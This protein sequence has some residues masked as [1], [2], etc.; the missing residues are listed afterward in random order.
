METFKLTF[1]HERCKEKPTT[2][3]L[4]RYADKRGNKRSHIQVIG[5]RIASGV[6]EVSQAQLEK[7]IQNGITWMG[8]VYSKCPQWGK[9]RRLENLWESMSAIVVDFDDNPDVDEIFATVRN[10]GMD[11][12]IFH[13]TFNWKQNHGKYRG[14][15][16]LDEPITDKQ[17]AYFTNYYFESLFRTEFDK[18]CKDLARLF[19]GGRRDCITY[20]SSFRA[21]YSGFS[22]YI[23]ESVK[24]KVL[25]D[26]FS[27]RTA[28]NY[29]FAGDVSNELSSVAD[30]ASFEGVVSQ[31]QEFA[32]LEA[33]ER[34][35]V[36][37]KVNHEIDMIKRFDGKYKNGGKQSRYLML[38]NTSRSLG[39]IPS[40]YPQ[41]IE[42][43]LIKA[44]NAN[45]Y[46]NDWDKNVEETIRRG[47]EYGRSN[48]L[49]V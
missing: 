10:I 36:L 33:V 34:A 44:I 28:S 42:A 13:K 4:E 40:L 48:I 2:E 22:P 29:S 35:R 16:L 20:S 41:A 15:I 11:W 30:P 47:I 37:S 24:R 23:G 18:A 32:K 38:W 45:P 39:M 27:K 14:I 17:H 31:K 5:T 49:N 7:S 43:W 21:N 26:K 3:I 1:D 8:S 9:R 46:W 6:R 25:T 19:F 12:T